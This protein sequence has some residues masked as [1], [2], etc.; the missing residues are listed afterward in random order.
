M[1][2]RVASLTHQK[3]YQQKKILPGMVK[4]TH[5]QIVKPDRSSSLLFEFHQSRK[6]ILKKFLF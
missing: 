2:N 4:N 5:Y 3:M 6:H 1:D